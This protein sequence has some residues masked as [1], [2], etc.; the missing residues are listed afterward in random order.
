MA[1]VADLYHEAL[2]GVPIVLQPIF[3]NSLVLG[4]VCAVMLNLIMRIGVRQRV[5][6]KLA[7]GGINR[8]AVE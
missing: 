2:I 8:E 5:S 3:R 1:V 6:I 4:T 7:P